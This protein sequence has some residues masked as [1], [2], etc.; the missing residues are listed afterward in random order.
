[1]TM[2]KMNGTE[3]RNCCL[4]FKLHNSGIIIITTFFGQVRAE[5]EEIG[6][7]TKK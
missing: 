4:S 2:F 6:K 3:K 1:M 5:L 7:N